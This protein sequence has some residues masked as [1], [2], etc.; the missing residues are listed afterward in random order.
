MVLPFHS[1]RLGIDA[2]G[3]DVCRFAL[4]V[5]LRIYTSR[6]RANCRSVKETAELCARAAALN[7]ILM[8]LINLYSLFSYFIVTFRSTTTSNTHSAPCSA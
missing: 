7:I 5:V 6:K 8:K 2:F 1:V 4:E 3:S